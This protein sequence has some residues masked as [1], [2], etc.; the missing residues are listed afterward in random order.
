HQRQSRGP[1]RAAVRL[2]ADDATAPDGPP[3]HRVTAPGYRRR[4]RRDHASRPALSSG[5]ELLGYG[6]RRARSAYYIDDSRVPDRRAANRG[7]GVPGQDRGA[8]RIESGV[9]AAHR[10]A[11]A[12]ARQL[13]AG[14]PPALAAHR[15]RG[16]S[17]DGRSDRRG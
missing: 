4:D 14:E 16:E 10:G 17:A 6:G 15:Q 5:Y 7:P 8:G 12:S 3:P 9:A 11:R 13:Y 2:A 1:H